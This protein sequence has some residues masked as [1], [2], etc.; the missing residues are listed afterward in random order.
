[1][2]SPQAPHYKKVRDFSL[3]NK[4]WILHLDFVDNM[5]EIISKQS[6]AIGA[7]GGTS[8]ERA[9]LGIPSIV[10]PLAENQKDIA[11]KL[12]VSK[13]VIKVELLEF[14]RKFKWAY[15]ELLKNWNKYHAFN[16]S[17]CD[18]RGTKRVIQIIQQ[19]F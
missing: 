8:W 3:N 1:L 18:G 12:E 11:N 9:C 17:I 10:I 4:N 15:E 7:P 16:L 2:L 13:A 19:L 6:I 14:D 5:A